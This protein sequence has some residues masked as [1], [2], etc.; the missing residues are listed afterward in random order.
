MK[1]LKKEFIHNADKCG[2]NK[3]V[4][5]KRQDGVAMYQR[6]DLENNSKGYE[7]F[8]IKVIKE[9]T[10]L[11]NGSCVEESY[12]RYPGSAQFGKTAFAPYTL[13]SA[14]D[15]FN[16]LLKRY[17][18]TST[19]KRGRQSKYADV[20]VTVPIGKFTM[21]QWVDESGCDYFFLRKKIKPLIKTG[22][23]KKVGEQ[24]NSK[25]KGK[26]QIVYQLIS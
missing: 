11:P 13:K 6:F 15:H 4:Q 7:V 5:I 24:K 19:P 23:V 25:G 17:S 26:P 21:K 14:N 9:G 3:F 2:D 18:D 12:E 8:L 1:L 16:K 20:T 10:P 22:K